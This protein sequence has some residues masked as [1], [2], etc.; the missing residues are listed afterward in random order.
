[1]ELSCCVPHKNKNILKGVARKTKHGN[2]EER[3]H[4][5]SASTD[6]AIFFVA[7]ASQMGGL[8]CIGFEGAALNDMRG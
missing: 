2:V 7:E 8:M 4:I 1:M 3:T 5:A 6:G